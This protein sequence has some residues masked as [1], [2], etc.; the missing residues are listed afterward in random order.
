[1]LEW[2]KW[3]GSSPKTGKLTMSSLPPQ[4]QLRDEDLYRGRLPSSGSSARRK[5]TTQTRMFVTSAIKPT[6]QD[7]SKARKPPMMPRRSSKTYLFTVIIFNFVYFQFKSF[8]MNYWNMA[9]LFSFDE[10]GPGDNPGQTDRRTD[11]QTNERTLVVVE[12]ISRLKK[13][14]ITWS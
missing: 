2:E 13:N 3:S 7:P 5:L 4:N 8:K 6:D 9:L 1:M 10:P 11:G 14:C 12:S